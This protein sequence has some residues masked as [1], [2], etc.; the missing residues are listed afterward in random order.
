MTKLLNYRFA[1]TILTSGIVYLITYILATKQ[2]NAYIAPLAFA[3]GI[4][5]YLLL[6]K[7]YKSNQDHDKIVAKTYRYIIW[8]VPMVLFSINAIIFFANVADEPRLVSFYS[9]DDLK[10]SGPFVIGLW[11]ILNLFIL[12]E[13]LFNLIWM[14]IYFFGLIAYSLASI[15]ILI[16]LISLY[17]K[18]VK[19]KHESV[20]KFSLIAATLYSLLPIV[21]FAMAVYFWG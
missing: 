4:G 18:M 11:P 8:L 16:L 15:G 9:F 1:Y 6:R 19:L 14:A 10:W 20:I 2:Y 17:R 3:I 5:V 7:F 21:C 12:I 13:N